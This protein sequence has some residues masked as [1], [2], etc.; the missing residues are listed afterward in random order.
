MIVPVMEDSTPTAAPNRGLYEAIVLWRSEVLNRIGTE[1][2]FAQQART[3]EAFVTALLERLESEAVSGDRSVLDTWMKSL[4][5]LEALADYPALVDFTMANLIALSG[6]LA[7]RSLGR[8]LLG[9]RDELL[10]VIRNASPATYNDPALAAARAVHAMVQNYDAHYGKH[11]QTTSELAARLGEALRLSPGDVARLRLAGL[12]HDAGMVTVPSA[13]LERNSELTPEEW[14]AI[15]R[16]P[17]IGAR[18]IEE[19]PLLAATAPAVRAHH[20]RYDGTGYPDGLFG[21][22]IPLFARILAVADAFDALTSSRPHR[23]ALSRDAALAA[24]RDGRG[25]QWD[26]VIVDV[27]MTMM[28]GYEVS[29]PNAV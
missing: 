12:V 24:I 27:L 28:G 14:D 6:V 17:E 23:P 1:I 22:R 26:P 15:R 2:D 7:P 13:V 3:A 25:T 8:V 16:H 4:A 21:E 29:L 10:D 18:M 9:R 5:S 19:V 11:S 20:E